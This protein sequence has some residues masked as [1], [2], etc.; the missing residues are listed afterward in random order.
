MTGT[1]ARLSEGGEADD[2]GPPV[3][4]AIL[5]PLRHVRAVRQRCLE[6][7]PDPADAATSP[8][9]RAWA[10]ALGEI[11]VA[12]VSGRDMAV[13]PNRAEIDAELALADARRLSGERENQADAA[14]IVLRWLIGVDDQVPVQGENPG[15]LVGG[16]GDVVRPRDEIADIVA[17]AVHAQ[18]GAMA[19]S[20]DPSAPTGERQDAG[21]DVDYLDGI[22][23]TLAW[24]CGERAEAPI[25]HVQPREITAAV[26]EHERVYAEDV[27]EQGRDRWAADWLPSRWYGEGV[28]STINWLLGDSTLTPVEQRRNRS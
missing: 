2:E 5:R 6:Q 20:L 15:E 7:F 9:A 8:S 12:P 11:A 3:N 24:V 28:R 10:W 27:I 19:K 17:L 25:T 13:P 1:T 4:T 23:V 22:T 18:R 21:Q 14:A 26:L 16:F